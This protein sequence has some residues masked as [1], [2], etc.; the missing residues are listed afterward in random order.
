[1]IATYNSEIDAFTALYNANLVLGFVVSFFS[2]IVSSYV[3]IKSFHSHKYIPIMI[4][5]GLLGLHS[6]DVFI[7]VIMMSL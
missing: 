2:M 4:I 1:M 7:T 5:V 6:L 3:L